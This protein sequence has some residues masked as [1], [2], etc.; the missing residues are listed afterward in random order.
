[1][2]GVL[3]VSHSEDAAKGIRDIAVK[4]SGGAQVL[5]SGVGG[6]GAGGLGVSVSGI[7]DALRDMLSKTDGV[8]IVP[9]MGSSILSSRAA[10]AMLDPADA[11]RSIIADAPVLEGAM[12]AAVEASIGSDLA[13]VAKC[14]IEARNLRKNDH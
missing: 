6:D 1:M 8:V 14:A 13:A 9:D 2:I 3:V 4:M 10:V 5:I 12:M 7:F 11:A